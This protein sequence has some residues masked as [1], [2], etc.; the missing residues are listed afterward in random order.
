[1]LKHTRLGGKRVFCVGDGVRWVERRDLL[2]LVNTVY[3]L[4]LSTFFFFLK[5]LCFIVLLFVY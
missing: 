2:D 4:C 3:I 5:E 1:M